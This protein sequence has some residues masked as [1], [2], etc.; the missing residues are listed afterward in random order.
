MS[1]ATPATL[2]VVGLFGRLLKPA[3]NALA[4]SVHMEEINV[5]VALR[6][7]GIEQIG[8]A[9]RARFVGQTETRD[10]ALYLL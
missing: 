9:A 4:G 6:F 2:A 5:C 7:G 1:S 8:G 10:D 3:L